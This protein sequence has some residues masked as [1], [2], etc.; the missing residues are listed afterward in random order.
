MYNAGNVTKLSTNDSAGI[1]N[2]LKSFFSPE[3]AAQ[4]LNMTS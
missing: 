1:V 4:L 3:M 2:I